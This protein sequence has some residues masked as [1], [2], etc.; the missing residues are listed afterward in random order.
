M[1]RTV[2]ACVLLTLAVPL[3]AQ[4]PPRLGTIS[5]P[6][7]ASG[8]AQRRFEDGV[9]YMHSFEYTAAARAFREAQQMAPGFAMAYW[10][11]AMTSNHP[12]WNERNRAA[13]TAVLARLAPTAD[14]RA[15]LAPTE[16]E[17]RWLAAAEALWA[18]GPKP[19]R[20]TAYAAM[21]DALARDYPDD[22]EAGSFNA[23]ALMGLSQATRNVPTYMRAAGILEDL[24]GAHPEHPGVLHYLIHAYD[25]PTHAPLGLRAARAYS[26]VAPDAAHAQH[27]TTHIFLALGMWDE[28]VSQNVIAARV[29]GGPDRPGHYTSWLLYGLLQQGRLDSA[30]AFLGRLR[31][32]T[33]ASSPRQ[34][35]ELLAE[36]AHYLV[37]SERWADDAANWPLDAAGVGETGTAMDAYALGFAALRRGDRAAARAQAARMPH[38]GSSNTAEAPGIA[39][40]VLGMLMDAALLFDAGS[41][42]SAVALA[43]AAARMEEAVPFEFGPPDV[44]KPAHELAGE[45]LL[46]VGRPADAQR[47][48]QAALAL[49]PGRSLSLRGLARA[50]A[51]AGDSTVAR[52]AREQLRRNRH[53]ADAVPLPGA[54]AAAR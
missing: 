36:R 4:M 9:L 27:M 17:R 42:D 54:G 11:E 28:T 43:R 35:W 49:A 38:A 31:A 15:A 34:R 50:A 45:M 20:D 53:A 44:V 16:R 19:Q 13:A 23:L 22:V 2:L 21:M 24:Y 41:H 14:A 37:N 12:L 10:G 47:E 30:R 6:T 26:S 18:D 7:S 3:V 39:P 33:S 5:F 40:A 52:A 8:A 1:R 32:G 46:A 51:E 48:F 29:A 25:D